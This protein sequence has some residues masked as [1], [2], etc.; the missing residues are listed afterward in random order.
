MRFALLSVI[1][2]LLIT[3]AT[4]SQT[5]AEIIGTWK[6]VSGKLTRNDSVFNYGSQTSNSMKIVTPT[7]FA[8]LSNNLDGSF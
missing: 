4:Y 5:T 7:H 6:L 2:C 1:A 3:T 8:V